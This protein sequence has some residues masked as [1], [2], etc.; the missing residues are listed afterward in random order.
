ML[1]SH[2]NIFGSNVHIF[3]INITKIVYDKE[4]HLKDQKD[5]KSS[6]TPYMWRQQVNRK[7]I[8]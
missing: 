2:P 6:C 4:K 7:R 1:G 5:V 8:C 3:T